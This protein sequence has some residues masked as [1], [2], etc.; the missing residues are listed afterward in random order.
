M[1]SVEKKPP[2][3]KGRHRLPLDLLSPEDFERLCLW[4]VRREGFT[5]V[6]HLGEV[7]SEQGRDLVA[8]RDGKRFA[9]QCKRVKTFTAADARQE[10][11]KVRR[12]PKREQPRIYVFIV[13]KGVRAATRKL[14]RQAWGDED[15][16]RFWCGTELD[17]R[18]KRYPEI[19]AE[20]FDLG[21]AAEASEDPEVAA[22]RTWALERFR[23][24]H[25]IGVGGGDVKVGLEDV[26]VPL[27][28]SHRAAMDLEA[29]AGKSRGMAARE[30]TSG[31]LELEELFDPR[32][33]GGHP[34][35]F[36]EPGAGKTT[37]LVKILYVC[38]TAGPRALG[39]DHETVA[40][41]LPLR[42]LARGDLGRPLAAYVQEELPAEVAP[43][44]VERLWQRGQVVL[45]LDGL[46]EIGDQQRREEVCSYLEFELAGAERRGIRAVIS[47]RY[48]GYGGGTQLG[49]RFVHL[50]VRPPDATQVRDLV[51][52]WFREVQKQLDGY[53]ER[54]ARRQA[55]QLITALEDPGY[56]SQ[57]L[58]VLVSSPLFLTL[59]CV[60]VL[61]GGEMP[62][63]RVAFYDQCLRVL[64]GKWG[65]ATK[66]KEPL[67]DVETALA[68]LRPLAWQLHSAG[69]RDDYAKAEL[70]NHVQQRLRRLGHDASPFRVLD[71]LHRETG[72]IE[73]YTPLRYGFMHLG[74]QEYLAAAH[75]AS[76]GEKRLE[77]L[78]S[79][80]GERW[81]REVILLLLGLPGQA[82]FTPFLRLVLATDA[83]R[84]HA[85][86]LRECLAE[87]PEIHVAPFLEV[88]DDT[89]DPARQAAVLRLLRGRCD[90]DLL[91]RAERLAGSDHVDLAALAR[92][93]VERC[94]EAGRE[95]P[96]KTYDLT[97]FH[98]LTR[99]PQLHSR[100]A[101]SGAGY[102]CFVR[103]IGNRISKPW[104][105]GSVRSRSW[106]AL[107]LSGL[108]IGR[109]T[110]RCWSSS[111]VAASG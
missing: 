31:D 87:A 57:Q 32:L 58:K 82:I 53:S 26:Y 11:D 63:H 5:R 68:V 90:A 72:V 7:G 65:K 85:A 102:S 110:A 56:S 35:I 101:S 103:R 100:R 33:G 98:L 89:A 2:L 29:R 99:R 20:F 19:L 107:A 109:K 64:L 86:L 41:F 6:E 52:L 104:S 27:R 67:L 8:R 10:I 40:F 55:D 77:A 21:E 36:G 9:F 48:S 92:Q 18:I 15:G 23:G 74:L 66:G 49:E 51:R 81:W 24:I 97:L 106:W 93:A 78:S 95:A 83:L 30:Q 94:S 108:G 61:R 111:P 45:L 14:A 43:G 76:R 59:L 17:E 42:R 44:L 71:W 39:L 47:C 1:G 60:V 25:L 38:C 12:L 70:A 37:A 105:R 96:G 75:V 16:C 4:L 62:R 79:H 91:Q 22:Y 69:R 73:E 13:S 54:E 80:F 84:E 46:D 34:V 50:D 88:L 28:I 3:T